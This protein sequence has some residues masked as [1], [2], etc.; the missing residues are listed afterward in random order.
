MPNHD[1]I[2]SEIERNVG[3]FARPD[4]HFHLDFS[5][6]IPGF[7][8]DEIAAERLLER[9]DLVPSRRIFVTPDNALIPIRQRLLEANI[10][11]VLPTYGL[12]DGFVVVSPSTIPPGHERYASWLDGTQHF[13]KAVTLKELRSRGPFDLIIAGAAAVDRTGRRFGMGSF[14]LDIEWGV[15]A[16]AELVNAETSIVAV[17]HDTQISDELVT[18]SRGHVHADIV[19]TPTATLDIGIKPRPENLDWS[20]VDEELSNS[21]PLRELKDDH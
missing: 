11:L 12:H 13:G 18:T 16:E 4:S 1:R 2:A 3:P 7:V 9:L 20:L 14:Y 21:P 10:D 15:F 17:V 5:R 19:V 8:G 6:F